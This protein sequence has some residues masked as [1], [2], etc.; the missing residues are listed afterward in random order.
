M[1]YF[2]FLCVTF[3]HLIFSIRRMACLVQS[4]ASV[5]SLA[6][7]LPRRRVPRP[8][9]ELCSPSWPMAELWSLSR[10]VAELCVAGTLEICRVCVCPGLALPHGRVPAP[11]TLATVPAPPQRC[12][13]TLPTPAPDPRPGHPPSPR[14]L[15]HRQGQIFPRR[16]WDPPLSE[17]ARASY[18]FPLLPSLFSSLSAGKL[19]FKV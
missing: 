8:V 7:D 2:F 13:R 15:W 14:R 16:R 6:S 12:L 10:P 1:F 17:E 19:S 3:P 5:I 4:S 11:R 18:N 9:T